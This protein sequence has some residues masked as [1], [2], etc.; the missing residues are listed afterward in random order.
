LFDFG[1]VEVGFTSLNDNIGL[2]NGPNKAQALDSIEAGSVKSSAKGFSAV[3]AFSLFA[4]IHAYADGINTLDWYNG[5]IQFSGGYPITLIA[6]AVVPLSNTSGDDLF[7]SVSA[8]GSRTGLNDVRDQDA[9]LTRNLGTTTPLFEGPVQ[10]LGY[11]DGNIVIPIGRSPRTGDMM[12]LEIPILAMIGALAGIILLIVCLQRK[13]RNACIVEG[14]SA[15]KAYK[16]AKLLSLL[17]VGLI[18]GSAFMPAPVSAATEP[19]APPP[20][21]GR[22]YYITIEGGF[23]QAQFDA[24]IEYLV[25]SNQLPRSLADQVRPSGGRIEVGVERLIE[26]VVPVN[27]NDA[28]R[29][30]LTDFTAAAQKARIT[31]SPNTAET[32]GADGKISITDPAR[33]K[34]V[35]PVG[36]IEFTKLS[37]GRPSKNDRYEASVVYQGTEMVWGWG[38]LTTTVGDFTIITIITEY[39]TSAAA[40]AT[41]A[42]AAEA[43]AITIT[44][45]EPPLAAIPD[46]NVPLAPPIDA[47]AGGT[48]DSTTIAPERVPLAD[49]I[50][51]WSLL[52]LLFVIVGFAIVF[53]SIA[54]A[55]ARREGKASFRV[56]AIRLLSI[57]VGVI[58][59]LTWVILDS[60]STGYM[61]FYNS[62]TMIVG[63]FFISTIVV[64]I[65]ANVFE[66]RSEK[67]DEVTEV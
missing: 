21:E 25:S 41:T 59:L 19:T 23:T 4:P 66:K 67:I 30:A 55:A 9:V 48:N 12:V 38:G 5:D 13:R 3:S 6:E 44:P 2:L 57:T 32:I 15:N 26:A 33:L 17:M 28:D 31:P 22:E 43:P 20:D 50:T 27:T 1:T 14:K 34:R 49:T 56:V 40:A 35:V 16:K 62:N 61:L 39:F 51:G 42:P 53:I 63:V 58:T 18:A 45:E 11:R 52:S 47:D 54:A 29:L 24:W 7:G 64:S 65:V 60:F 8:T 37:S 10:Q 46:D 36:G